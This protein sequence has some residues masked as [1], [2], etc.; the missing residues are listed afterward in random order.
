MPA[1]SSAVNFNSDTSADGRGGSAIELDELLAKVADGD[2]AAL[3]SIYHALSPSVL[4]L[5]FRVVRDRSRAEEVLQE[6]FLQ[7][8]RTACRYDPAKGHAKSWVLTIA[9]RR[10]VDTVRHDQAA[11]NRENNYYLS[12]GPA[13]DEVAEAATLNEERLHVRRCLASLSTLQREAVGL[14][15][16]D[17]HTYAEVAAIVGAK[18][19]TVKTR[20]RDGIVRLRDCMGPEDAGSPA[21]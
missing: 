11:T 1:E 9:H 18:T 20:M 3:C 5:A 7:V 10:A 4:G 17:G 6:V 12:G 8:W 19:A 14:A 21:D 2:E 15:Y 13:F 16:Y